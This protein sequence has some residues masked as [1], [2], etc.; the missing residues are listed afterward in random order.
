MHL[1]SGHEHTRAREATQGH[2]RGTTG[3][4]SRKPME[5]TSALVWCP[6]GA[7]VCCAHVVFTSALLRTASRALLDTVQRFAN[8]ARRARRAPQGH[9]QGTRPCALSARRAGLRASC[10]P[11]WC[12]SVACVPWQDAPSEA[13]MPRPW[14]AAPCVCMCNMTCREE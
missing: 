11:L 10:V 12:P 5:A 1:W 4:P 2:H 7:L 6:C 13:S 9:M 3:G 14:C 8:N